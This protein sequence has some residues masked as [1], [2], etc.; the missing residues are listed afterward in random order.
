M[1]KSDFEAYASFKVD[2]DGKFIIPARFISD[3]KTYLKDTNVELICRRKRSRRSDQQNRYWW[4]CITILSKE[5]G[6]TKEETHEICKFKFLKREKVD[7]ATGEVLQ[8]LGSTAKLNKSDF[9]DMTSE[10]IRW[11]AETFSVVLPMPGE[12]T[13]L[14]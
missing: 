10:L 12:Q 11:S 7:E 4:A 3:V 6:Y 1:S 14:I 9:A 2:R 8:Y 13:E 5:I